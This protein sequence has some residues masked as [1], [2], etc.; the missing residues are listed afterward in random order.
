MLPGLNGC[1]PPP[2]IIHSALEQCINTALMQHAG[3][4]GTSPTSLALPRSP[5]FSPLAWQDK[6][7]SCCHGRDGPAKSSWNGLPGCGMQIWDP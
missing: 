4:D 1:R 7:K 6:C 2:T 3:D 5:A